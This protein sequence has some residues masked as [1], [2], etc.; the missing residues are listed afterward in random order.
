MNY[1]LTEIPAGY[2][3]GRDHG[4]GFLAVWMRALERHV[5]GR[6]VGTILDL[7]CGTGRFSGAL[8]RHFRANVVGVHPSVKMLEQAQTKPH[9]GG[10]K[11]QLGSAE[12][13]PLPAH[14]STWFSYR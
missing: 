4:P 1:D 9:T 8:A 2:D 6:A 7:G 14:R 3:R 13:L 5:H 10:V 12:A 11:Y